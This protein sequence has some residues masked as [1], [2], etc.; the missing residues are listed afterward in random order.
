MIQTA[1]YKWSRDNSNILHRIRDKLAHFEDEFPKLK[2]TTTILELA[3]WKMKINE[4]SYQD[5]ATQSQKR[6]KTNKSSIR[7]QCRVTC[8]ADVVIQHVLP[9]LL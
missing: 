5:M 2:E 9:F 6:S 8:G 1:D 4:K 7:Q 3:L